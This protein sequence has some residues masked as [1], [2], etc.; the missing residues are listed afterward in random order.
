ESLYKF[1]HSLASYHHSTSS[2]IPS[3]SSASGVACS[4]SHVCMYS[5]S[6]SC[7]CS[8]GALT[9][10]K[11]SCSGGEVNTLRFIPVPDMGLH[12]S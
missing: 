7:H 8:G 2:S 10:I 12:R 3:S 1:P 5:V 11:P 9:A 4:S 6:V